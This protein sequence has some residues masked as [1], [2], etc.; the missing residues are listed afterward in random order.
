[1]NNNHNRLLV[2]GINYRTTT[3]SER[4]KFQINKKELSGALG[5]ITAIKDVEGAVIISTCNR[6]EFYLVL[7][8]SAEPF[9]IIR[10]FYKKYNNSDPSIIKDRFYIYS[11]I[12]VAKH[13]YRVL[14][15]LES[16]V[17][18]EYQ[19]LGQIKDAYSIACTE[20]SAEKILHKLFHAG[21]R[22]GK[23]VRSKTK[24]GAGKQ[25]VSGVA[26][27]IISN[28]IK[29]NE[30]ITIIGIN[31][32]TKIIADKLHCS[33][34]SKIQFV[35]RTIYKAEELAGKYNSYAVSLEDYINKSDTSRCILT[36][37]GAAGSILS[38]NQ[39]NEIY[40]E[41]GLPEL[42][43]DMAVPRDIDP[44]GLSAETELYDMESL[45]KYLINQR[46]E[47]EQE[48]PLAEKIIDDEV[49]LFEVWSESQ[50]DE[51]LSVFAEKIEMIRQQ[52]LEENRWQFAEDEYQSLE[53][54]SRSL[55][56]RAKAVFN[57]AVKSNGEKVK[58][59]KAK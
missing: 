50:K 6:L 26:F 39:L 20:K 32:S 2:I 11:E 51:S 46:I 30:L 29:N 33:G 35:N 44:A 52:L 8:I 57:Q 45:K 31:E 48:I 1:M 59:V 34:Y 24:I 56:H 47:N 18:G 14:S 9:E 13:L 43:V 54:F 5:T 16:M 38:A 40:G 49:K 41:S 58:K 10:N 55:V 12:E 28:R 42:I 53:K 17:F 15:G 21:F 4:E 7:N 27:E 36:C 23:N 3:I 25:S 19:I 22:T 37:T